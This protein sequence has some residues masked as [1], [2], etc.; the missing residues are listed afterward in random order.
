MTVSKPSGRG[1][2]ALVT[3]AAR[4][5]GRALARGCARA[6]FDVVIHYHKSRHEAAETKREIEGLGRKAWLLKA[7]LENAAEARDLVQ[8]AAAFGRLFALINSA[9]IFEERT[10]LTTS[11]TE[12]E[13][14]LAINLTAPFVLTKAFAAH[15]GKR[16]EG[17]VVNILDWRAF[18]PENQHF[19][20]GI[21]KA[22]LAAMTKSGA[23]ALAPK[24]SV[25]GLALGAILPVAR[26]RKSSNILDGVPA[27]RWGQLEEVEAALIFLLTGP[28]Y[29]TGEI[30]HLDGG[31]HLT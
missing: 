2:V 8:Q 6:G 20:Y 3:G 18:R 13:R 5:I 29:I 9:A 12:W 11:V 26:R 4:R 7:D 23:L 10:L 19:A 16:A 21:C 31:R 27:Q 17:R 24:I 28:A 30:M 14:D 22:A 1:E 25:N 15:I